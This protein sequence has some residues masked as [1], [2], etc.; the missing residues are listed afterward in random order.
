MSEENM[1]G[2]PPNPNPNTNP[3]S[4]STSTNNQSQSSSTSHNPSKTPSLATRIQSSAAGLAR[5]AFQPSTDTAQTLANSTSSKPAPSSSSF[6][7]STTHLQTAR[8][9]SAPSQAPSTSH[10]PSRPETFREDVDATTSFGLSPLTEEEF[11]SGTAYESGLL[12]SD[13]TT[14][15][16]EAAPYD[17]QTTTGPWKGKA[18]QDPTQLQ[19]ET[20]WQRQQHNIQSEQLDTDGSAVVHLLS[21]STFDPNFEDPVTINDT[22]LDISAAPAPLS[23]AELEALDSFRRGLGLGPDGQDVEDARPA[24]ITGASLVPDIDTFL[25]QEGAGIGLAG[26][27]SGATSLR[28]NVLNRLPGAGDWV[29]VHERYHDEVWGYLEPVLEAAKAEIEETRPEGEGRGGWAGC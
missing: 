13:P 22:E 18:R 19:F 10:G 16:N 4:S 24:R 11:Q 26:T 28:D 1:R 25:S 17:L 7:L 3:Q 5:S 29:G 12:Q 14:R 9:L 21:D 6:S 23:A 15:P 27:G 2:N 8:D 20:A